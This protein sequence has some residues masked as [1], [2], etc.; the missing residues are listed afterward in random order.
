MQNVTS[1]IVVTRKNRKAV[2]WRFQMGR[3]FD[4]VVL[5]AMRGI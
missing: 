2:G 1:N 5:P 3:V 4:F